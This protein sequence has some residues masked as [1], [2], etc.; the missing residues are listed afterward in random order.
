MMTE[1]TICRRQDVLSAPI[2]EQLLIMSVE[3]GLYF[4]FNPVAARIWELLEAP[5][6]EEALVQQLIAEYDVEIQACRQQVVQ[7][8]DELKKRNLLSE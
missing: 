1:Q 7:F 8:L 5:M 3:H 2:D 4:S 6:T